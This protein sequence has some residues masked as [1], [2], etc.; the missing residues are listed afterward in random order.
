MDLKKVVTPRTVNEEIADKEIA[1]HLSLEN[2]Y[3]MTQ[4]VRLQHEKIYEH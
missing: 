4:V 3:Q 2:L 1:S